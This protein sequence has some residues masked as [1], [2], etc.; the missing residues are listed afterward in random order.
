M[1]MRKVWDHTIDV[2]EGVK[3]VDDGLSFIFL[4]TFLFYFHFSF[5]L[6]SIFRTTWARV[7]RSRCHIS[8]NL[9]VVTRSIMGLRRRK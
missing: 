6:F 9:M 1:P 8:H 5:S 2:K 7:D 4:R 3:I